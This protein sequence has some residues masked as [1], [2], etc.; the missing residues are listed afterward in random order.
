MRRV[1]A[2]L[3]LAGVAA[4][5]NA[6]VLNID[7][8]GWTTWSFYGNPAN[9]NVTIPLPVGTEITGAEWI[10][11]SFNSINGSWRSEL[12]LSLN[13][14]LAAPAFWDH[15]PALGT[16]SGGVY[17]PASGVFS[18]PGNVGGGPFT[19]ASGNLFI[20]AYESFDDGGVGTMDAEIT[21]GTLRITY[22]IPAPGSAALLGLG[23][24]L[25]ARRRR[26]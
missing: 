13:D 24:L 14:D 10:D 26:R 16:N 22:T 7:L 20:T 19:L 8:A 15:K 1:I 3:A 2:V 9:S 4:S 17:G 21:Q 12:V 25:A 5:A 11:L 23:G 18:D 6:D